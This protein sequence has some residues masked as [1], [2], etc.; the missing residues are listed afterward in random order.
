MLVVS[1]SIDIQGFVYT[2][3][4]SILPGI[5]I[6]KAP[7]FRVGILLAA[8]LGVQ[9]VVSKKKKLEG[10]A[11]VLRREN[12]YCVAFYWTQKASWVDGSYFSVA[13]DMR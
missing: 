4:E 5:H 10:R 1:R 7:L 2:K 6:N 11:K 13:Q 3:N 8:R 9:V 12:A